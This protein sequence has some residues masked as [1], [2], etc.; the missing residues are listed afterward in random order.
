LFNIVT[1][2]TAG[3]GVVVLYLALFIAML[4]SALLLVPG[5]LLCVQLGH[6]AGAADQI[7]LAWLATSIA[8]LGGC[9]RRRAGEPRDRA[10]DRVHLP[11]GYTAGR[12]P[13][14]AGT[15]PLSTIAAG[16]P[17]LRPRD[18]ATN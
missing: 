3:I 17:S 4:A 13:A 7:R 9:A 12:R 11:A 18:R 1:A 6:P 10:R 14:R 2:A 16:A 8:T 15:E 5:D